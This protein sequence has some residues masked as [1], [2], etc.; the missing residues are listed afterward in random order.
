MDNQQKQRI[1]SIIQAIGTVTSAYANT[2]N[3]YFN[4]T[5]LDDLDLIGMHCKL[6]EMH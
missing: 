6:Q 1:G 5:F 4:D 2:P 3:K